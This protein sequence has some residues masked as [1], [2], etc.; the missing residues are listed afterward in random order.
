LHG[1]G[2]GQTQIVTD[3]YKFLNASCSALYK[4]LKIIAFLTTF[5]TYIAT[6]LQTVEQLVNNELETIRKEVIVT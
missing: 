2:E 3:N 5:I 1:D 6:K 4:R